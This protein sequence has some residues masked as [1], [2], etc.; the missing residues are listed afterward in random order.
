MPIGQGLSTNVGSPTP[1]LC[2]ANFEAVL[3][4]TACSF[5]SYWQNSRAVLS[6]CANNSLA[7]IA[8][9]SP[10]KGNPR[11]MGSLPKGIW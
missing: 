3:A 11:P 10:D 1:N 2:A 7:S 5:L 8:M 9:P 6:C 4:R